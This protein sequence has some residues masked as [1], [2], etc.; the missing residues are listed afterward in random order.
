MKKTY[1]AILSLMALAAC[2]EPVNY[3]EQA[4]AFFAGYH[5]LRFADL[6]ASITKEEAE[7]LIAGWVTEERTALSIVKPKEGME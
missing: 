3:L 7:E 6:F 2:Q 4:Q 1:I 5:S